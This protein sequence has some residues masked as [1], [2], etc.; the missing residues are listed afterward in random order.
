VVQGILVDMSGSCLWLGSAEA[1]SFVMKL[2]VTLSMLVSV[3]ALMS[4]CLY[5]NHILCVV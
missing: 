1:A 2:Q 3:P 5:I 4:A